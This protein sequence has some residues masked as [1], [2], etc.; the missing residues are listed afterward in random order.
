MGL[1]YGNMDHTTESRLTEDRYTSVLDGSGIELVECQSSL[2]YDSMDLFLGGGV[3][4]CV[5]RRQCP[6]QN[7]LGAPYNHIPRQFE[8]VFQRGFTRYEK[9]WN[10]ADMEC[11]TLELSPHIQYAHLG[12]G[13]SDLEYVDR[14][15]FAR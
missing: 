10:R 15:T 4:E 2:L 9:D 8:S 11:S 3:M 7:Q 5:G 14:N 13:N 1:I 12:V 6:W